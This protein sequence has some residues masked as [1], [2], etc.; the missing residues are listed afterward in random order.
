MDSRMRSVLVQQGG[1]ARRRD[2]VAR[3]ASGAVLG[4]LVHAGELIR[5]RIG[6]YCL[7]ASDR[8]V[9]EAVRVGGVATCI[10]AAALDGLW[11]AEEDELHVCVRGNGSQFRSRDDASVYPD[12]SERADVAFHWDNAAWLRSRGYLLP[13][14]DYLEHLLCC[15]SRSRAVC[16]LD[17]ALN[18]GRVSRVQL[19]GLAL[20]LPSVQR[21]TLAL[22]DG[23]AESGVESLTRLGFRAAGIRFEIQVW[24]T[25][26]HRVDFLVEGILIVEVDGSTD[27][28]GHLA[29]T[30]DRARDAYL[31]AI[32]Y[33]VLHF[34]YAM[35]LY[36]WPMVLSTVL[37]VLRQ[38]RERRAKRPS[39]RFAG[40]PWFRG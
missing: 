28:S 30:A 20:R 7:A 33:R 39:R 40:E 1:V 26:E 10:S 4:A 12:H 31:N 32:G 13:A 15:Q 14:I 6:W 19:Q 34:T 22:A 21:K 37:L 16:V 8:R 2:L 23:R 27:H 36:D 18:K 35:V 24:I 5:P 25:E 11:V 3:G 29:F 9:V 17:S 38:E